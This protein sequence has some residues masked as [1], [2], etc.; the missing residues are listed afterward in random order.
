MSFLP[1]K[2]VGS[3]DVGTG[4]SPSPSVPAENPTP[5]PNPTPGQSQ[6]GASVSPKTSA[7]PSRRT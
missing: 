3:K 6:P 2:G 5:G 4:I 1:S 7:S